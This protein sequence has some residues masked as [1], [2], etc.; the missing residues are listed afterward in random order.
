M[1][2]FVQECEAFIKISNIFEDFFR[3]IEVFSRIFPQCLCGLY[4]FYCS[5]GFLVPVCP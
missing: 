2:A 3:E 1:E 5:G 4:K